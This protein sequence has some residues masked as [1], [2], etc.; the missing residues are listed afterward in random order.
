MHR[1]SR[2]LIVCSLQLLEK[3]KLDS[4]K[5]IKLESIIYGLIVNSLYGRSAGM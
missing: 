3:L 4:P 1:Q 5:C 2:I